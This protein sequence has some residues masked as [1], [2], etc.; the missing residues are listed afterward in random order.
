H[1]QSTAQIGAVKLLEAAGAYW[2]G[3]EQLPMLQ[4]IYGT[5]FATQRE[6]ELHLERIEEAKRRDHRRVGAELE[7]FHIDPIAPGS[8]FYLPKGMIVYNGLVEFIRS[9]YPKYGYQEVMAPQ[10]FRADLFKRS[11]HYDKF[12]DDMFWFAGADE[13]EELGVKAMNCPGHCHMFGLRKRSYRE[14]PLRF[15]EFS[16]LHRNERSG[17]L[18][19]L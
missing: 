6:L 18:T 16:R 4:R 2:R 7:L 10:L 1:V 19:G 5:A 3:N 14:L 8:P 12:H 9:L 13:G 15:A 17:T 11:G